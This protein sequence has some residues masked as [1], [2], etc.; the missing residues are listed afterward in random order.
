MGP[1][2][3]LNSQGVSVNQLAIAAFLG[4][5]NNSNP[6]VQSVITQNLAAGN[7]WGG[8]YKMDVRHVSDPNVVPLGILCS[9]CARNN[10]AAGDSVSTNVEMTIS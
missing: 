10:P 9:G 3:G 6:T 7:E 4:Q 2:S 5:G 8:Y 1:S